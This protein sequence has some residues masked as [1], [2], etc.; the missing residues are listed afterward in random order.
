MDASSFSES[1]CL[2]NYS[3]LVLYVWNVLL[4]TNSH[5]IDKH[6]YQV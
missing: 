1:N 4:K 2:G 5:C 6:I 3:I